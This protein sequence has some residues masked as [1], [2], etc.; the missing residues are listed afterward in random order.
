ML[1]GCFGTFQ[2]A[3]PFDLIRGTPFA[4]FLQ[5]FRGCGMSSNILLVRIYPIDHPLIEIVI[6][7]IKLQI[8]NLREL[9]SISSQSL[10]QQFRPSL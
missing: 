9:I 2:L 5:I 7:L 8:F 10:V 4:K 3:L 1:I 6:V